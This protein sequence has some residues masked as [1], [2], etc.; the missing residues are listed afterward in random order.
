MPQEPSYI[1]FISYRHLPLDMEAAKRIQKK[2]ENYTIP[3]DFREQFGGKKF[4]HV[5]RD[6]D[7]LPST[8]SLSDSI[9]YALDRSKFLIVICTPDL[10]QSRWCEA[11]I[12]YFLKTHDRDH[13]L[14]VLADGEPDQS[15]SPYILHDFDS[16]GNPI[17]DYEPLAANID[18][19]NHTLN[20]RALNKEVT[21]LFAA[22]LGCPFD[23]LW[24][25]EKRAR[26][27]RLLGASA[28][29]IAILCA[30]LGVVL[31]RNA[32]IQEQNQKIEEQNRELQSRLSTVLVNGGMAKLE[33]HDVAG[34]IED[35]LSSLESD[36]PAVYDHRAGTLLASALG[37][38]KKKEMRSS[39]VYSQST[40]ITEMRVTDDKKHMLLLDEVGVLR[41]LD[42]ATY[43]PL[44][45]ANTGETYNDGETSEVPAQI[46]T[47]NLG[48]RVICKD[49]AGVSCRSVADGTLL[50]SFSVKKENTNSFQTIS[51][52]GSLFAVADKN[53]GS[54]TWEVVFLNTADGTERGR[55]DLTEGGT[56][57]P[58]LREGDMPFECAAA[59]SPD[60]T[61]FAY[62]IPVDEAVAESAES[63]ESIEA[64][65]PA[66]VAESIEAEELTEADETTEPAEPKT[67]YSLC[68]VDLNTLKTRSVGFIETKYHT[69]LFYGM[70]V[71]AA[72]D[73]IFVAA[74]TGVSIYTILCTVNGDPFDKDVHFAANEQH[75]THK[76]KAKGGMDFIDDYFDITECRFLSKRG[77]VYIFSDNQMFIYNRTDNEMYNFYPLT[78]SIVNAYW[79]DPENNKM[80]V[81]TDDGY[82]TGYTMSYEGNW[83]LNNVFA[84]KSDQDIVSKSCPSGDAPVSER[85]TIY[86]ISQSA[87]G[88]LY[89]VEFV[90]DPNGETLINGR[91]DGDFSYV[92]S[93]HSDTGFLFYRD[94]TVASFDKKSGEIR[95][96]T[97][98]DDY[99]TGSNAIILDED[100]FLIDDDRYSMDGTI[101]KYATPVTEDF[102]DM[103]PDRSIRLS[104]GQILSWGL[105]HI[106][107]FEI[108]ESQAQSSKFADGDPSAVKLW[109]N[110]E[111]VESL[112]DP[113][114]S[115]MFFDDN[116]EISPLT[117][118]GENGLILR[119]GY[120]MN[121]PGDG[122]MPS[123]GELPENAELPEGE[124]TSGV[125]ESS[126]AG[127][128]SGAEAALEDEAVLEGEELL[129][130]EDIYVSEDDFL[131]YMQHGTYTVRDTKELCIMDT[132]TGK[133]VMIEPPHPTTGDI[134]AAFAHGKK[135][136]AVAY[137]SGDIFVYDI[138]KG[139]ADSGS[140]DS[141]AQVQIEKRY[142]ANEIMGICFSDDDAYLVVLTSSGRLD[143]YRTDDY[144]LVFSERIDSLKEAM[145]IYSTDTLKAQASQDGGILFLTLGT[146]CMIIDTVGWTEIVSFG[147]D[148]VT[149]DAETGKVYM[150]INNFDI[151]PSGAPEIVTYPCYDIPE[152]VEWA[153]R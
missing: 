32:R 111:P 106:Y 128:T 114:N 30:F 82:I 7:E 47:E 11:E 28:V 77:R 107:G 26:V 105:Y 15:F 112:N 68:Y 38:Y 51:D 4:G 97:K 70:D 137:E 138:E 52:D 119:Y 125:G 2:I 25:R 108:D 135:L 87:P 130:D 123:D 152:L 5:F 29:A 44:W 153:R 84:T 140:D 18:G 145:G 117:A 71:D 146:R 92:L 139:S 143:I 76:Y 42:L 85:G 33:D 49:D 63:A 22:F 1:A 20:K 19:P 81:I 90:S 27:N 142:I 53:S 64:D 36:D 6:E 40:G 124:E 131:S 45:E 9:Y 12:K 34:A 16:E 14:A 39:I 62:I 96:T 69:Y 58:A 24:Q 10:P 151:D 136:C 120:A 60:N 126:G 103:T 73:S 147:A 122:E 144:Q 150:I 8:A 61:R 121:V 91:K 31:N 132:L 129:E 118:A 94:N 79:A 83:I 37:A 43:E 23:A 116:W 67:G 101:D 95:R 89:F 104:D 86:T 141:V 66:E 133:A 102:Y 98:F 56:Y 55:I 21:R 88:R 65:E 78:G 46:Y 99:L 54:G 74:Y 17:A 80:E 72:D 113:A 75:V 50:W 110:G 115:E 35:A 134:E 13:I 93:G 57:T 100:H 149:Y 48:D 109:L 41:C 3:K 59:F 127:E 148:A